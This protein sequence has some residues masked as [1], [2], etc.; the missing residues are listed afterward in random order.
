MVRAMRVAA[1]DFSYAFPWAGILVT[2]AVGILFGV[3]AALIPARQA[4]RPDA[5]RA[6]QYE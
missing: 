1:F 6:L 5:V 3:V 4:A 2:V